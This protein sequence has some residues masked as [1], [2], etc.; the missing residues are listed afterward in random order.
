MLRK[1]F[2]KTIDADH[3]IDLSEWSTLKRPDTVGEFIQGCEMNL[4][5]PLH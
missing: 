3:G 4:N 2:V 1:Q 5:S